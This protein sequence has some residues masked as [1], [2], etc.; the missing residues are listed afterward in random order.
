MAII[1]KGRE[2]ANVKK[3]IDTLFPK[4]NGAYPDKIIVSLQRDHKKWDETAREISKQLGYENK[5]DF[6]TAYGYKIEKSASGRPST[7]N[8]NIIEELKHR[9]PNGSG[10]TKTSDLIN[11]NPDL[12]SSFKTL[13]NN[14]N[15]LFGMSLAEYLKSI[16][17]L[18]LKV[19]I[20]KDAL[21]REKEIKRLD[22]YKEKINEVVTILKARYS[23][24]KPVPK[25]VKEIKENNPDLMME[26][27]DSWCKIGYSMSAAAYL[28][29]VGI[30]D[31]EKLRAQKLKE[32]AANKPPKG[33]L[34]F[35]NRNF[36]T[37]NLWG[38][39]GEKIAQLLEATGGIYKS[40][41]SEKTDYLIAASRFTKKYRMAQEFNEQGIPVQV[42]SYYKF[43]KII[44]DKYDELGKTIWKITYSE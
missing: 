25:S 44:G 22:K 17:I 3:R 16:G 40:H 20:D 19:I 7:S 29:S 23:P 26:N 4:L 18:S 11:A 10:F 42:I 13:S 15:A 35:A 12:K 33:V 43:W 34:E 21:K 31:K 2:P 30:L 28:E 38:D 6:L 5:N 8:E 32:I 39:Q 36:V 27:F 24:E 37:T 41:I 14:A 9:Y 1:P